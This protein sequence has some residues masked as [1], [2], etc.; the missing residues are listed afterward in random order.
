[1]WFGDLANWGPDAEL[2]VTDGALTLP[3]KLGRSAEFSRHAA[4]AGPFTIAGILDQEDGVSSDGF[5]A[6]YRLYVLG[7]D[8]QVFV[9]GP[10]AW[11]GLDGAGVTRWITA[12]FSRA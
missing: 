9:C 7:Y 1:V 12:F 4:P 11:R 10:G 8:G 2:V 6:G 5:K 3:V